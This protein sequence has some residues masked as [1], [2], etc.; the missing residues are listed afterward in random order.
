[1]A[2]VLILLL[3]SQRIWAQDTCQWVQSRHSLCAKNSTYD[4]ER[5]VVVTKIGVEIPCSDGQ[6]LNSWQR[7]LDMDVNSVLKDSYPVGPVPLPIRTTEN[8][9]RYRNYDLLKSTYGETESE[10]RK[11]LVNVQILGQSILFNRKNGAAQ[12]LKKVSQELDQLIKTDAKVAEFVKPW[13]G[14]WPW[15]RTKLSEFAYSWRTV[16]GTPLLSTHSF[17]IALDLTT[18]KEKDP[19]YWLWEEASRRYQKAKLQNPHVTW[20][21]IKENLKE[22]DVE[23]YLPEKIQTLPMKVV[24]AFEKHG[25]IWGAKWNRYD[26]MHFEYR[27]EMINSAFDCRLEN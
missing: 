2:L 14:G 20:N 1:M 17:G 27:P 16:A 5:Q 22:S 24:Q 7:M 18:G 23:V 12:A 3:L 10:V 21:Q 6:Q 15:S 25:F 4:F 26:S 11:N 9:G 19:V 13:M 8:P